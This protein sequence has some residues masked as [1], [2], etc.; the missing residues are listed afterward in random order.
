VIG[1]CGQGHFC[2]RVFGFETW[3]N[4]DRTLVKALASAGDDEN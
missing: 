4:G 3:E 2:P 1:F